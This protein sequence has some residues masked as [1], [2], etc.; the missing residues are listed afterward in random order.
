MV[1]NFILVAGPVVRASSWEPT[2]QC[3]REEGH[4]VQTPDVLANRQAPP[5]WSAWT[6]HLLECIAPCSSPVLVGHSSAGPAVADLASKLPGSRIIIVDGDVPPASGASSPGRPALRD[7][8]KSLADADGTLPIYSRWFT[9]DPQRASRVGIDML[10]KDPT[11]F[12]AF[13]SELIRFPADWFDDKIELAHWDH[14][15]AGFI[16]TSAYYDDATIEA[17]RRG[18]PVVR[19]HGTHFHLTLCPS[20]TAS[21][22]VFMA[23]LLLARGDG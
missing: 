15:P 6:T 9:G 14:I 1:L 22:I 7:F 12:A 13:E 17:Y 19:L 4:Q 3:L 2:A 21:A 18:W 20:E 23:R 11:A 16:Q 8:I 10:A 5:P